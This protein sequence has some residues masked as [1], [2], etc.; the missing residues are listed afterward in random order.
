MVIPPNYN[1][2]LLVGDYPYDSL[3][4][5]PFARSHYSELSRW[6]EE[7]DLDFKNCAQVNALNFVPG[8]QHF[9]VR[10]R[11]VFLKLEHPEVKVSLAE[12]RSTIQQLKPRMIVTFGDIPLQVLKPGSSNLDDERGAPYLQAVTNGPCLSTYHPRQI[13]VRYKF[14]SLVVH[15]IKKGA[16]LAQVGWNPPEFNIN[17][18]PTFSECIQM[19]DKFIEHKP[20][21]SVDFECL[22]DF[23]LTCV[24]IAYAQDKA[25]VI[26]F[27]KEKRQPYFSVHE[28]R[29]IWK[30]LRV[31]LSSCKL[32]GHNA[33]HF[34]HY[35]S[36]SKYKV[37]SNFVDDTM[38]AHWECYAEM[39]KSLGFISSLYTTNPYWKGALKEARSGKVPYWK[40][41]EYCGRDV[42]VCLQ[43]AFAISK[44]L[45]ELSPK[46]REHYRFNIATSRAFQYMSLR[47]ARMD[48]ELYGKR[49]LELEH[50][51]RELIAKFEIESGKPHQ[52]IF[53]EKLSASEK[54]KFSVRSPMKMKNWLYKELGLPV[55]TKLK[56]NEFGET[57]QGETAD[58]LSLLY[59]GRQY[60]EYPAVTTAGILRRKLKRISTLRSYKWDSDGY[61]HWTFNLT[62]TETG[63]ASGYKPLDGLGVQPQNVDRNDRD[64]FMPPSG[65]WWLKADLEGA[66]NWTVAAML[67]SLGY[68]AMLEDLRAGLKPAQ[69]LA[70]AEMAGWEYMTK[71]PEELLPLK[72]LLK[73][74]E[75]QTTYRISKA[76]GHGSSYMMKKR[77]MHQNIFKQSDGDLFVPPEE[78]QKRQ[79]MLNNFYALPELH[80]FMEGQLISRGTLMSA[81]GTYRKFFGRRDA[82]TLRTM[83]SH[84]P[85]AHTGYSTNVVINRLY[86]SPANRRGRGLIL[87]HLNQVHDETDLA[88]NFGEEELAG[89]IF[90]SHCRVPLDI[91]GVEVEIPFEAAYGPNWGAANTELINPNGN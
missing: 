4:Q 87:E 60:P 3:E 12:L 70:I 52:D 8:K 26:P 83:L 55:Q 19:L 56:K 72:K 14:Q 58:Y 22:E 9:D 79:D 38:F 91:W 84:L 69:R 76:V 40:E 74:P 82:A 31:V 77:M 5:A 85:Q 65:K 64:L 16:R 1:G 73:S 45:K 71:P 67:A 20:Y 57:E 25:I 2:I 42:I 6:S 68:P 90:W 33:V 34:D 80:K 15:D 11:K 54:R 7:A 10:G 59:L 37:L 18:L 43:C 89:E 88:F 23:T 51:A 27:F 36:A 78:C 41:Y 50:E 62:G 13:F 39:P 63:R 44:E 81:G 24:G 17:F 61:V 28:E 46:V 66:D 86:Y 32:V 75:G 21:L 29:E 35:L 47:G 49:V 48:Q 30:R 53:E